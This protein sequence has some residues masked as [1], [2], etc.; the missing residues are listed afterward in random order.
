MEAGVE[1]QAGETSRME[2]EEMASLQERIQPRM[3]GRCEIEEWGGGSSPDRPRAGCYRA[4]VRK[5][6][7]MLQANQHRLVST[8]ACS[9]WLSQAQALDALPTTPLAN[10]SK[11]MEEN[12]GN[13]TRTKTE[14]VLV[15]G[16][17]LPLVQCP[18]VFRY[19][20][21]ESCLS[22]GYRI[23]L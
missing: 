11:S 8:E 23:Y 16:T 22:N 21:F 14:Q 6:I 3:W 19:A 17:L 5:A 7:A 18:R 10:A 13:K 4:E 15:H 12:Q 20:D 2:A 1:D 9:A